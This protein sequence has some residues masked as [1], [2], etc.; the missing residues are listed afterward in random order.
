MN[1]VTKTLS[2]IALSSVAAFAMAA[3]SQNVSLNGQ[4]TFTSNITPYSGSTLVVSDQTAAQ[5]AAVSD[6]F[7]I[8]HNNGSPL[9][10]TVRVLPS[11]QGSFE[12]GKLYMGRPDIASSN[13]NS[14]RLPVIVQYQPC[15]AGPVETL[16][17]G[18]TGSYQFDLPPENAS[19]SLC[20]STPGNLVVSNDAHTATSTA[21]AYSM[22]LNFTLADPT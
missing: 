1:N 9:Q 16:A 14:H 17:L 18:A 4:R 3:A 20:A 13:D 21:G 5:T 15:N 8:S 19:P 22:D 11:G 10:V 7:S 2:V 6:A 12:S